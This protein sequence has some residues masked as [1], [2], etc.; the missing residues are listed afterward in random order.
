MIPAPPAR[1]RRQ[2]LLAPGAPLNGIDYVEVAADQIHLFVR[3]LNTVPVAGSPP[4][5]VVTITGGGT[6]I[7]I[8]VDD[9]A[10]WST[11]REER[12]VLAVTV[13]APGG[14]SAY[15]LAIGGG[16]LDPFFDSA[17]FTFTASC[18]TTL[19]YVAPPPPGPAQAGEQVPVDYLA[20]DFASFRQ[21]LSEFSALRYPA[22][23]ERSEADLGVMMM[24]ALAAIGDEL[25]YYQDRVAA[26][27]AIQTATQR[28]SV[29][30]HARLVDYEPAPAAT[31]TTVLQLDVSR[32]GTIDT[33][34][35]VPGAR[36]GRVN[37]RLRGRGP[38]SRPRRPVRR[39]AAGLGER[40]H[41]LE[42]GQ[43]GRLLLG[44]Q[45]AVPARR[46]GDA[47]PGGPRSRAVS[48]PAAAA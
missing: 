31:A 7:T 5:V 14:F 24:E 47:V 22:W 45:P 38:G 30:R 42:P 11:D 12:P 19:D 43:P 33:P 15:T 44:R 16:Q 40:R 4:G 21:A 9:P 39:H 25:S 27:S 20:K 13:P 1:D 23:V 46:R 26:E 37:H 34:A 18:P 35:A 29:V 36:R 17:P 28:L 32:S 10:A 8:P 6:V 3:F 2:L 41:A 48:R